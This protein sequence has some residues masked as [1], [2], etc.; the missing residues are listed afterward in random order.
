MKIVR[1]NNPDLI[2]KFMTQPKLYER[3]REDTSPNPASWRPNLLLSTWLMVYEEHE[4]EVKVVGIFAFVPET[5]LIYRFHPAIAPEF[6]GK[7][8]SLAAGKLA[9]NWLW[10]HTNAKKIVGKVP[11]IYKDLLKWGQRLGFAREGIQRRSFLRNG[12][13]LDQYYMGISKEDM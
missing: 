5:E 9:V 6:W 7:P 8:Q 3:M 12:E 1:T 13:L 10:K 11:I 2:A 4:N